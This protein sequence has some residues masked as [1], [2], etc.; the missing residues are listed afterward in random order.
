MNREGEKCEKR[1]VEPMPTVFIPQRCMS[2]LLSTVLTDLE[3]ALEPLDSKQAADALACVHPHT[4]A[5]HQW[6]LSQ[7]CAFPFGTCHH[8]TSSG[9]TVLNRIHDITDSHT[10]HTHTCCDMLHKGLNEIEHFRGNDSAAHQGY[11][12]G[13]GDLECCVKAVAH[14]EQRT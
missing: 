8:I 7:R 9:A 4:R 1:D 11:E 14:P 2:A 6:G 3:H 12:T 10:T 5:E 13:K